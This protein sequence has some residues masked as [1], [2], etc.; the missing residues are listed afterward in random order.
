[1]ENNIFLMKGRFCRSWPRK[2]S[3]GNNKKIHC[4]KTKQNKTKNF[5][6]IVKKKIW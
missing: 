5:E 3:L 4:G 1:M 2:I 6:V